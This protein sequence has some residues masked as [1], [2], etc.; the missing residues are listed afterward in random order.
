MKYIKTLTLWF[1]ISLISHP[2]WGLTLDE[3]VKRDG[4][5]YKKFSEVPF[6]GEVEGQY[7]GKLNKGRPDGPWVVYHPNGQLSY[8]VTHKNGVFH[9]LWIQYWENGQLFKKINYV[10]GKN[11][12]HAVVYYQDGQLMWE[13]YYDNNKEKGLWVTYWDNGQLDRTGFYKNGNKEGKWVQYYRDGS[14][15][16]D[17]T[18]TFKNGVKVS[19]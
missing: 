16:K 15:D 10:D 13:G 5:F 7:Q 9:G 2:S 4:I 12:G 18:G 6:T 11:H 19:N 8:K 3:L 17:G 14:V 1:V